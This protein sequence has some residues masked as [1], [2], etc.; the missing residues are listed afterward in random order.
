MKRLFDYN[1]KLFQALSILTQLL[2]LNLLFCVCCLPVVTGGCALAGL[3]AGV[4]AVAENQGN[5]LHAFWQAARRELPH[6][7]GGWLLLLACAG[8]LFFDAFYY[9]TAAYHLSLSLLVLLCA[10][11]FVVWAVGLL[12][13]YLL[14]LAPGP[15]FKQLRLSFSAA[16]SHPARAL[17]VCVLW[18]IFPGLFLFY[19]P[20]FLGLFP[21]WLLFYFSGA[22]WLTHRLFRS[23]LAKIGL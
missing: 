9:Y 2:L 12:F 18:G 14:P 19:P 6:A 13:F 10:A 1:N 17:A 22:A 21:F 5:I 11:F 7:T 8:L 4:R 20:L 16:L 23:V 15:L 3:Y